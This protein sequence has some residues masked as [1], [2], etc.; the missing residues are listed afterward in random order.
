MYSQGEGVEKNPAKASE[1]YKKVEL[2]GAQTGTMTV[3]E[4]V[5]RQLLLV[6]PK[7]DY[8]YEARSR[9]MTGSGVFDLV[10]DYETGNLREVH[11][12][13]NIEDH[14]LNG[15]AIGALKLWKAKKRS[16]HVLRVPLSFN[17][18]KT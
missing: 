17:I 9:R 6:A 10:F 5:Q 8:P 7:P 3:Q 4:A 2:Q 16:I 13:K 1:L 15:Y 12:V 14:T 11:V 18:R